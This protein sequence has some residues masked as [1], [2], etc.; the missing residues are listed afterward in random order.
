[1][2]IFEINGSPVKPNNVWYHFREKGEAL[3]T[4]NIGLDETELQQIIERYAGRSLYSS[5]I[6]SVIKA[7]DIS[8][9]S[10]GLLWEILDFLSKKTDPR[11]TEFYWVLNNI[12]D[13][14]LSDGRIVI[15]GEASK[16]RGF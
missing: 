4:I 12:L 13:F 9:R 16:Y 2:I 15:S 1:M 11:E 10:M 6:E 7:K 14:R 5:E 8:N 3:Y